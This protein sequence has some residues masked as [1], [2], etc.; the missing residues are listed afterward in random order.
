MVVD[1]HMLNIILHTSAGV[2]ALLVGFYMLAQPKGTYQHRKLGKVFCYFTLLVCVCA[3]LGLIIFRFLPVFSVITLLV[4]YQL[5][6][7][8][9]AIYT[10]AQGPS[11]YDGAMTFVALIIASAL[12]PHALERVV[13][14]K[15]ILL[16]TCA[17]VGLMLIYDIARWFFPR[18]WHGNL[19]RYEHSYKL[20]SSLFGMLSALIG[21]TVR[22]GQPWSQILPSVIGLLCIGYFFTKLYIKQA[23]SE[24]SKNSNP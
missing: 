11:F 15:I 24:N 22:A 7:G 19:W 16:S 9:R 6:S 13:G 2:I 14:N 10:R 5:I 21:N 23:H 20:I 12:I 18:G 3:A 17:A 1:L 4:S 8:W